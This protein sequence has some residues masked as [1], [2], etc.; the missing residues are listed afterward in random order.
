MQGQIVE[1]AVTLRWL[2]FRLG[3]DSPSIT[4]GSQTLP[5]T[6]GRSLLSFATYSTGGPV[7]TVPHSPPVPFLLCL[8]GPLKS[9]LMKILRKGRNQQSVNVPPSVKMIGTLSWI[10]I[11]SNSVRLID[12]CHSRAFPI[13]HFA[14]KQLREHSCSPVHHQVSG[15]VLSFAA[16]SWA[17]ENSLPSAAGASWAILGW[18]MELGLHLSRSLPI[19]LGPNR[20]ARRLLAQTHGS[21]A[22]ECSTL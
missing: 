5:S 7:Q 10:F 1:A 6:S 18:Q 12:L 15:Q 11:D 13:T 14:R 4:Q 2:S 17:S 22:L 16:P 19:Q 3:T 8:W 9:P 21:H 20:P